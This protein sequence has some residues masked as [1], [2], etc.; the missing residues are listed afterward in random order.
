MTPL[1]PALV[2]ERHWQ[3]T[4]ADRPSPSVVPVLAN[5]FSDLV[6]RRSWQDELLAA[7]RLKLQELEGRVADV[8]KKQDLDTAASVRQLLLQQSRLTLRLL[9]VWPQFWIYIYCAR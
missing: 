2:T 8:L 5:G 7:Q 4:L 1:K 6:S 3:Q 9:H